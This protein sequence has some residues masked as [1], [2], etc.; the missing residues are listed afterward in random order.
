MP[1]MDIVL[2][3]SSSTIGSELA[4]GGR[5]GPGDAKDGVSDMF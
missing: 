5:I 3:G 4:S 1:R 2:A